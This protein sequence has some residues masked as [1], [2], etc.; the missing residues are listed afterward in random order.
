MANFRMSFIQKLMKEP[1][2]INFF[3]SLPMNG[4][5]DDEIIHNMEEIKESTIK[6]LMADE[7]VPINFIDSFQKSTELIRLGRIAM[8]GHSISLMYNADFVIFRKGWREARGCCVEF[9]VCKQYNI[10]AF[11]FDYETKSFSSMEYIKN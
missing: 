1:S 7:T 8:L 5:S 2:K 10:P 3:I 4:L 6:Y 9:E 11:E